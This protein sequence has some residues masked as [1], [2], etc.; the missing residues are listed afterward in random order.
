MFRVREFAD[1]LICLGNSKQTNIFIIISGLES[2]L[3][4]TPIELLKPLSGQSVGQ[5]GY[6]DK[7]ID[8]PSF[9]MG[10]K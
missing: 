3:S 8:I 1:M 7:Q 9:I 5:E 10:D 4:S 2:R 6:R